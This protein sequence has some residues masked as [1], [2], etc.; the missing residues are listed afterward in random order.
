MGRI[1][2]MRS[3]RDERIDFYLRSLADGPLPSAVLH[4]RLSKHLIER[5]VPPVDRRVVQEDLAIL[6]ILRRV[7]RSDLPDPVPADLNRMMK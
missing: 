6:Q 2:T 4:E 1:Q 3:T 7:P 5:R